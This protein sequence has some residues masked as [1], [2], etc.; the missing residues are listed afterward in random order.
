LRSFD[1]EY[2]SIKPPADAAEEVTRDIIL[3]FFELAVELL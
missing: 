1:A 2:N 3:L